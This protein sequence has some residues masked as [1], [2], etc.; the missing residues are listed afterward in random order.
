MKNIYKKNLRYCMHNLFNIFL[1]G[2]ENWFELIKVK[3]RLQIGRALSL[4]FVHK[5]ILGN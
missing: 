2:F 1:W 4:N 5:F 3:Q